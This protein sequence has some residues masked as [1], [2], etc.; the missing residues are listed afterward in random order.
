MSGDGTPRVRDWPVCV[1]PL[2]SVIVPMPPRP[3]ELAAIVVIHGLGCATVRG[4]VRVAGRRGDEDARVGGEEERDLDRI[5][6]VRPRAA[7][8]EVD[9]VDAVLDGLVDRGDAVGVGATAVADVLPADLVHRDARARRHAADL[10]ER[11][12]RHRS[13]GRRC[14]RRPSRSCGCR[15]RCSRAARGSPTARRG[16][17]RSPRRSTARRSACG[18][19]STAVELLAGVTRAGVA[20]RLVRAQVA[21]GLGPVDAV[22]EKLGCSGQT[23]V[24]TTPMMTSSP[25]FDGP[26]TFVQSPSGCRAR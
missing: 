19:S 6:E 1:V 14:C 12:P 18:C 25:A 4:A 24:S 15:D 5:E 26:P 17:A 20:R 22:S 11:R 23:P 2:P 10:A 8:R 16:R 3:C 13:P 9:H 7:D 21:V